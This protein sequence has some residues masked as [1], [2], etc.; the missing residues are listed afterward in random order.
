MRI[1]ID[2]QGLQTISLDRGIGHYTLTLIK[3]IVQ[4]SADDEVLL[5]LNAAFPESIVEIR[6]IF[7]GVLCKSAIKVYETPGTFADLPASVNILQRNAAEKIYQHYILGLKPDMLLLTQGLPEEQAE[8]VVMMDFLGCNKVS[9]GFFLHE[10]SRYIIEFAKNNA[11]VFSNQY[12]CQLKWLI[13]KW[14]IQSIACSIGL[15]KV[16]PE[17]QPLRAASLIITNSNSHKLELIKEQNVSE[18]RIIS[19]SDNQRNTNVNEIA[20]SIIRASHAIYQKNICEEMSVNTTLKSKKRN[21]KLAIV[22]PLPPAKTGVADYCAELLPELA[23]YYSIDLI[24]DQLNVTNNWPEYSFTVRS[25]EWFKINSK[26]YDRV[27][28]HLGNNLQFHGHIF[29]LL[30][31]IPGV[32]I[33][34]DFFLSHVLVDMETT[35]YQSGA[36][37]EA[38]FQSHGYVALQQRFQES[39]FD[40]LLWRYPCNLGVLQSALGVIVHAQNTKRLAENWFYEGVADDWAVIPLLRTPA[41]TTSRSIAREA[42]K[43]SNECFVVCSFGMLGPNKLNQHL[44]EAW[45]DSQL[46]KNENSL[47]I[48][49]GQNDSGEYGK[50]LENTIKESGLENRIHITGWTDISQ[51]HHYLEAADLGVQLRTL[52]RGETSAAVLDCMNYGLPTIVNANGSMADLPNDAVWMLPD[53]LTNS[54][55]VAAIEKLWIDTELRQQLAIRAKQVVLTQHNPG[56]CA[57]QYEVEI[58]QM[59]KQAENNSHSLLSSLA[60]I[61]NLQTEIGANI[62]IVKSVATSF[63]LIPSLRQL[64]VDTS[65]VVG[66]DLKSGIERVVRAQLLELIKNPPKGFRVEPVYLT[67]QGGVWHYRYAHKYCCKLLGIEP[68]HQFDTPIDIGSGDVF[69]AADFYPKAVIEAANTGL[70]L[71]WLAKGVEINFL[72]HDLLPIQKPDFFPEGANLLFT[73]WLKTIAEVSTRLLCIS[74]SVAEGLLIWL[75]TNTPVR[76]ASLII[77]VIHNGA[78]IKASA[79]TTGMPKDFNRLLDRVGEAPTFIMVGTLEPRKGHL[80]TL[81]AIELLWEQ[82]RQINLVI[83]GKQGWASLPDEQRKS[84]PQLINKLTQHPELSKRLFWLEDVSDECL[85]KLY[86]ASVCLIAA[87]E[88]EGFGLPLIEAAHVKLPIIA[89]DIPVFREISG[90]NAYYFKGTHPSDL[91]QAINHWLLLYQNNQQPQSTN[92]SWLTWAENASLLGR[93]LSN[94]SSDSESFLTQTIVYK[95]KRFLYVDIS[96]VHHNDY[97]TGI[98]RVVRSILSELI[99]NPPE[100]YVVS[101]VFIDDSRG[102]WNFYSTQMRQSYIENPAIKF[103]K[104]DILLGL[105]LTGG[106]VVEASRHGM[107]QR[108]MASGT[109]VYFV[110]Y[111]LLPVLMPQFFKANTH[112]SFEQW[113]RVVGCGDGVVCISKAVADDFVQWFKAKDVVLPPCF[114]VDFFHLGADIAASE[115]TRGIPEDSGKVLSILSINTSF[116]MVGTVEPRK[117]HAQTLAAFEQLWAES[118]K[119]NL[120]IV[121]KQGWEIE[122]LAERLHNH[123]ELDKHLFWL[124][125]ASDEYLERL[126]AASNCLIAASEG[127]GFGLPLI[128]AAQHKLP[129]IARDIPVFR[130]VAG[131]NAFYFNGTSPMELAVS[132]KEWLILYEK[133]LAPNSS[134]MIWLTWKKSAQQLLEKIFVFH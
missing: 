59:Y 25:C 112:K 41:E 65:N 79:P 88:G 36:W 73:H 106:Y 34:H 10:Q 109:R 3:A 114:L 132:I 56:Q 133:G 74:N 107:Y 39:G 29:S 42:L 37:S 44:L 43:I 20:L 101:P 4:H 69:Y 102:K 26:R 47:L 105:D 6:H 5:V 122:A 118:H 60:S 130:E 30:K 85:E 104:G 97:K 17:Y 71:D 2:M 75:E 83:V 76:S 124:E 54:E 80:Q 129:I 57:Q 77:D 128:E 32:V 108:I 96:V 113:L 91:E 35:D 121:G 24:T 127:E 11:P 100:G 81:A 116:L 45:L 13:Q 94:E 64:L 110:V 38:L 92:I 31:E 87:S 51:F 1:I 14:L 49:V 125:G 28:Y 126:Y 115:P 98:Q 58:E 103:N 89:R 62:R 66:H 52:S 9:T 120:I 67:D 131:D 68:V 70:Y 86:V 50:K 46:S 16:V 82:G 117:G 55:L 12:F 33:L 8:D 23:R 18:E 15:K 99:S 19:P 63:P 27:L 21:L 7:S 40:Q 119:V 72:I 123:S 53:E 111:D 90:D 93:I 84:I 95:P 48:F 134:K 61:E 22:S 78:D